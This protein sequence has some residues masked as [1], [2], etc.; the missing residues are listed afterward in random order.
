MK[1]LSYLKNKLHILFINSWYPSKVLPVNGDFIQRHAEAVALKHKVTALHVI[2]DKN[3]KTNSIVEEQLINNVNTIIKY[4]KTT[5]N[6][7]VKY[8]Q[9]FKAYLELIKRVKNYDVVH[10]N[11]IYPA[12][13]IVLYLKWFKKKPYIISEHWTGYQDGLKPLQFLEKF[14]SKLITKNAIFVCPVSKNLTKSMLNLSLKGNYTTVP[15]VVNTDIFVPEDHNNEIF[16]MLH[17]SSMVDKHKNISGILEVAA[18]L[19]KVIPNFKLYLIGNSASTYN[20]LIDTLNIAENVILTDQ[21]AHT[22]IAKYMQQSDLFI[23]FSN[24]E[25][26]PCVILESFSCGLP[27]ISTNVGGISEYFPETYGTLIK[28]ND[29]SELLKSIVTYY[30]SDR[31]PSKAEM[32]TY[33]NDNFS[34]EIICSKFSDLYYKTLIQ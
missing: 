12:G 10:L 5:S 2:T 28:K 29:K 9:F 22:D 18:D 26:L 3:L 7:F 30:Y 24:Y 20:Y 27:V 32:H 6:P 11:R 19:K 13:L 17:V 25:N 14:I 15:N 8:I 23:L 1:K 33:A 4:C 21:I 34:P 16:T 31:I